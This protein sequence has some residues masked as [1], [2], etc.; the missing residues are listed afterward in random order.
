V[1]GVRE[2]HWI[3]LTGR[4]LGK[5]I[6]LEYAG[7]QKWKVRCECGTVAI[8]EARALR[9]GRTRSCGCSREQFYIDTRGY[10]CEKLG[11]KGKKTLTALPEYRAWTS[12][13][14]RCYNPKTGKYD[15]WYGRI[16]VCARWRKSFANFYK[17]MG[18]RPPGR[19]GG[20][21]LYSIDRIDND[22]D[23][24]P[25][26]CRWATKIQQARNRRSTKLTDQQRLEIV[27]KF[28]AGAK[29]ADLGQEYGVCGSNI[30]YVVGKFHGTIGQIGQGRRRS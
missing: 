7:E 25:G 27:R 1:R 8:R 12:M 17:D 30:S 24:R 19:V 2:S 21:P 23:Y 5:W 13:K 28:D 3:D 6:A 14:S 26:N 11:L 4:R 22:G 20:K 15:R 9:I 18:P 16:K 10:K 29:V